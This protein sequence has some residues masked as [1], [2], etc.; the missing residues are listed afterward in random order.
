MIVGLDCQNASDKNGMGADIMLAQYLAVEESYPSHQK[1]RSGNQAEGLQVL[2][3]ILILRQPAGEAIGNLLLIMRKNGDPK[4]AGL[5]EDIM[6]ARA[7]L[8]GN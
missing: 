8:Q 3:A 1:R 6:G 7:S 5:Q 4:K 2:K